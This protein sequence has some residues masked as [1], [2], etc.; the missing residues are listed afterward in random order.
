MITDAYTIVIRDNPASEYYYNYCAPSW[1]EIGIELKRFDAITPDRLKYEKELKFCEYLQME[2][3]IKK[4][5]TT[6]V[7]TETEKACW[8]SHYKLW[9][10]CILH[11]RPYLITEHDALLVHPERFWTD[12][13]HGIIFYD[14]GAMGSY[15]IQPWYAKML[16]EH[17]FYD[18]IE[19][20]PYSL[21]G[22]FNDWVLRPKERHTLVRPDIYPEKSKF[23]MCSR[24]VMSKT[25]GNT[26]IHFSDIMEGKE[27]Y[28]FGS[29]NFL[30]IP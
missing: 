17:L 4:G 5:I 26:I 13:K 12:N 14:T 8:Y 15:C 28:N 3:Y 20:G 7:I 30:I 24:Q 22:Y 25:H 27:K 1:K 18:I 19:G 2:K 11:N 16:V 23:K 21:I 29:H 6:A 10:D 9:Q